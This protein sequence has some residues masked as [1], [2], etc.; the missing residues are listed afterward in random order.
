[1]SF[2]LYK[3]YSHPYFLEIVPTI[4]P[5]LFLLRILL[6]SHFKNLHVL[7]DFGRNQTGFR[8]WDAAA[9]KLLIP[10]RCCTHHTSSFNILLASFKNPSNVL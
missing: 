4:P 2:V 9:N 5:A 3:V 6:Y 7:L 1:M 8:F 10:L